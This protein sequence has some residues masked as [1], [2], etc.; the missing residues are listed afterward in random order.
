MNAGSQLLP[1]LFVVG[2]V[3]AACAQRIEPTP[4]QPSRAS[5]AVTSTVATSGTSAPWEPADPR[6]TGCAGS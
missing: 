1:V 4:A 3:T 6:F 2:L 5:G